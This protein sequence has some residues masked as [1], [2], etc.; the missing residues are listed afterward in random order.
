M[1]TASAKAKGRNAQKQVVETFLRAA[2]ELTSNDM[3]ST[4]MGASGVDVLMSPIA[5]AKYPLAI[6]VKCQENLNIWAA[7]EQTEKQRY[8]ED[9]DQESVPSE[10]LAP[11][12]C[13][14]RNRSEIYIA[15]KLDDF[16]RLLCRG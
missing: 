6:E 2:P 8:P 9:D 10:G 7:M 15:L 3:R 5:R 16:L 12:V 14:K 13:F 4:S 11:V 1:K